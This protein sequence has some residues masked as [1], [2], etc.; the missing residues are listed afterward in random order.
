[1]KETVKFFLTRPCGHDVTLMVKNKFGT[2][3][4]F[5]KRFVVSYDPAN[6]WQGFHYPKVI[7]AHH[8]TN[9]EGFKRVNRIVPDLIGVIK[10][11]LNED[12]DDLWSKYTVYVDKYNKTHTKNRLKLPEKQ[13]IV[14]F[15]ASLNIKKSITV[16]K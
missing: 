3:T 6:P 2:H 1:M 4:K 7:L 8:D 10:Y 13:K 12:V 16:V 15:Q 11:I 5:K 9:S 14:F